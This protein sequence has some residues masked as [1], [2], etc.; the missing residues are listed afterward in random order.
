M[1]NIIDSVGYTFIEYN[2]AFHMKYMHYF[3]DGVYDHEDVC[4]RPLIITWTEADM[5]ADEETGKCLA[6][7]TKLSYY[8]DNLKISE[9]LFEDILQAFILFPESHDSDEE[10][11]E[12]R[13]EYVKALL[14]S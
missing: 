4:E 6:V 1:T 8:P 11:N 7:A 13:L 2:A 14:E 12:V 3:V 10:T 5:K 9:S